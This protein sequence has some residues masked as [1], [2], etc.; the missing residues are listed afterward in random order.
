MPAGVCNA[1]SANIRKRYISA[2]LRCAF[3]DGTPQQMARLPEFLL[4]V[5][6][7]CAS[8]H[9]LEHTRASPCCEVNVPDSDH[10]ISSWQGDSIVPPLRATQTHRMIVVAIV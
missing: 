9:D 7:E 2:R 8:R 10:S 5:K 3:P 1:P 4:G 6:Q